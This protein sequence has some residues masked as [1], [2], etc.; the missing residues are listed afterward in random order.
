MS[1]RNL[2]LR[3]LCLLTLV[4]GDGHAPR[5]AQSS[6]SN[7]PPRELEPLSDPNLW[8]VSDVL[9]WVVSI[10]FGEY[11]DA[12]AE[13]QVDGREL[14]SKLTAD[15]LGTG[16]LLGS[17]EHNLA[18]E[19]EFDELKARHGLLTSAERAA[20]E[21]AHPPVATWGRAE[22]RQFIDGLGLGAYG[23]RFANMEGH[24]LLQLSE[25]NVHSLLTSQPGGWYGPES[26]E[27]AREVFL[28]ALGHLRHKELPIRD[29]L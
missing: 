29:E 25:A 13:G 10:G 17:A 5:Y 28:A 19:M 23:A 14:L 1:L 18:I 4:C 16:L 6:S 2:V 24:R 8:E 12:F 15:W 11:R 22:V 9:A 21:A 26:D 7:Y 20:H 3:S 27:A